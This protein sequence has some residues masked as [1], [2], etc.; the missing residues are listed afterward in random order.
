MRTAS[1]PKSIL[2]VDDVKIVQD[3]LRLTLMGDYKMHI[4]ANA[5]QAL[6]HIQQHP[7]DLVFLDVLLPDMNGIDLLKKFKQMAPATRVIMITTVQDIKTAVDAMKAGAFDFLTKPFAIHQIQSLTKRALAHQDTGIQS[8]PRQAI[9]DRLG[10]DT[11]RNCVDK[12]I[13]CISPCDSNVLIQGANGTGKKRIARALH[14]RSTRGAGPYVAINCAAIPAPR[15]EP[16]L[17]GSGRG[18]NDDDSTESR[19]KIE[20]AQTGSLF[21]NNINYLSIEIQTKLLSLIQRKEADVRIIAATNQHLSAL[22]EAGLFRKGLHHRL[23]E[24]PID[25]PLLRHSGDDIGL[26]LEHFLKQNA[27]QNGKARKHFSAHARSILD[28]CDWPGNVREFEHLIERLCTLS[29]GRTM[30]A[31]NLPECRPRI[32]KV[33][34]LKTATLAFERQ[35]ILDTL[36]AVGGNKTKAARRLGI[37]RNTLRMKTKALGIDFP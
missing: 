17:F 33:L 16:T 19:G 10:R 35:Y 23:S 25:L 15:M 9:G 12:L 37:H 6:V 36:K 5:R 7:I 24:L 29:R 4:A 1:D 8:Q 13:D 20:L 14:N 28:T 2:I 18:A 3:T 11:A 32:Q 21:I 22:V 27:L 31:A 34:A 26:L 30:T